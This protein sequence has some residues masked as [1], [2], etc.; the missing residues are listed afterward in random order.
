MDAGADRQNFCNSD[1]PGL[2]GETP[3]DGEDQTG[4]RKVE[5][6]TG[7]ISRNTLIFPK[8]GRQ[9]SFLVR[10]CPATEGQQML[11]AERNDVLRQ[12]RRLPQLSSI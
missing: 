11:E 4:S 3:R 9:E 5:Q 12:I 1:Q 6:R 10:G 2:S 7:L 8:L